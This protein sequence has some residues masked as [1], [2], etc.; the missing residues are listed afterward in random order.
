MRS[1]FENVRINELENVYLEMKTK[2]GEIYTKV[3]SLSYRHGIQEYIGR[4]KLFLK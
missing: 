4:K 2:K 1:D 3:T